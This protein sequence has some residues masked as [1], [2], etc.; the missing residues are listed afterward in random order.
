MTRHWG[1]DAMRVVIHAYGET[2]SLEAVRACAMIVARLHVEDE[3]DAV[4]AL[5]RI[6]EIIQRV[7]WSVDRAGRFPAQVGHQVGI[8]IGW[9]RGQEMSREILRR[10]EERLDEL[11]NPSV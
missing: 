8:E 4:D 9:I 2:R 10:L 6:T 5:E 11:V 1:T 3:M 7:G